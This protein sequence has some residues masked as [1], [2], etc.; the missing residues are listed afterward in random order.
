MSLPP[1]ALAESVKW[2]GSYLSMRWRKPTFYADPQVL[3]A[4]QYDGKKAD[5]WSCGVMLYVMVTGV[6]LR[7]LP[8]CFGMNI[9]ARLHAPLG[10]WHRAHAGCMWRSSGTPSWIVYGVNALSVIQ[11]FS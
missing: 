4:D 2:P 9:P 5:I 8:A 7:A 11:N 3:M 6:P 1:W 10:R